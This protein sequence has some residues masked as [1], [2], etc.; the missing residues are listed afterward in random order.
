MHPDHRRATH[1]C[2]GR[3]VNDGPVAVARRIGQVADGLGQRTHQRHAPQHLP[4]LIACQHIHRGG[5]RHFHQRACQ[6]AVHRRGVR[7]LQ[8]RALDGALC[9]AIAAQAHFPL[10]QGLVIP[11]PAQLVSQ[12]LRP[13]EQFRA[14]VQR[15][16]TR[17][18]GQGQPATVIGGG[19]RDDVPAQSM[20]FGGFAPRR[21][22]R[23]I[24]AHHPRPRLAYRQRRRPL[25]TGTVLVHTQAQVRGVIRSRASRHV[26]LD[27]LAVRLDAANPHQW[28]FHDGT[29]HLRDA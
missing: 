23:R 17:V 29:Q 13:L 5:T 20:A 9:I 28:Q 24:H 4:V 6:R 16:G 18:G 8:Q 14:Q 21:E 15:T 7:L 10:K 26:H 25:A 1:E 12:A 3:R 11:E 2:Q 27:E 22:L 19:G